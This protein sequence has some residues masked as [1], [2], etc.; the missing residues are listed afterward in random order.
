MITKVLY[1]QFTTYPLKVWM[2]CN[3]HNACTREACKIAV[4][5]LN[6]N[7]RSLMCQRPKGQKGKRLNFK[8]FYG[9]LQGMLAKHKQFSYY[10][11]INLHFENPRW[12]AV[13]TSKLNCGLCHQLLEKAIWRKQNPISLLKH[14]LLPP[15]GLSYQSIYFTFLCSCLR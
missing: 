11:K 15:W 10:S 9:S 13:P 8:M 6:K 1:W 12:I 7:K 3:S 4:V 5:E 2:S 14:H